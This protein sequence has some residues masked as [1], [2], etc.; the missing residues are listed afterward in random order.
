MRTRTTFSP[1]PTF[2]RVAAKRRAARQVK[3]PELFAKYYDDPVGFARDILGVTLWHRQA[4]ILE[5]IRDNLDVAIKSGQKTGK[6]TLLI[7]AALWFVAT[8]KRAR[9]IMTSATDD[10]I[11]DTLWKEMTRLYTPRVRALLGGELAIDHRTGLRFADGREAKGLAKAKPEAMAGI[12]SPEML[13]LADEASGIGDP[14]FEAIEGNRAGKAR[15][16]M[17]SNPTRT[18]GRF[19]RAFHAE[20]QFFKLFTLSGEEASETG[21]KGLADKEFTR[22]RLEQWGRDSLSYQVRVLGNFPASGANNVVSLVTLEKATARAAAATPEDE[23]RWRSEYDLDLGVDVARF[24][25]DKSV[26]TPRRGPRVYPHVMIG[27]DPSA[28]GRKDA[29]G[30]DRRDTVSV[31]SRVVAVAREHAFDGEE[32][33]VKIDVIGVGGGVADQLRRTAR[34]FRKVAND[35][36]RRGLVPKG[37]TITVIEVNVSERADDDSRFHNLRSQL[38]I[39]VQEWLDEEGVLDA[40]PALEQELLDPTYT[41][42]ARGRYQVESKDD[43]KSRIGRSPDLADSLA[44]SIW[45]GRKRGFAGDDDETELEDPIQLYES[46]LAER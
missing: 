35:R 34:E 18:S 39:G 33:H 4:E 20:R 36:R 45:Q 11:R 30:F 31:A 7:C 14:M 29:D 42:D 21:I 10:S 19:Y 12:S 15:L 22:R 9:V 17:S 24:G 27:K 13:W 25:D 38:A 32:V 40:Q 44:L 41:F 46:P 16:V 28:E 6:T 37:F 8:R 26:I 1:K 3:G 23:E 5:A 43:V 2:A